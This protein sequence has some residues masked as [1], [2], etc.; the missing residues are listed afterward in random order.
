MFSIVA[1]PIRSPN[2]KCAK[3]PFS[4]HLQPHLFVVFLRIAILVVVRWYLIMVLIFLLI[5]DVEPLF[6]CL[7]A[8]CMSLEKYL[9]RS[10]VHYL[11]R[12]FGFF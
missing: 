8:I 5:S 10:T 11:I 3:F 4:P 9:F 2:V 12:L 6:M 7:F 1:A